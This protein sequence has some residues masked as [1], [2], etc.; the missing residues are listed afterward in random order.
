LPEMKQ[1]LDE[2]SGIQNRFEDN[3]EFKQFRAQGQ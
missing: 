2:V 3:A 1:K